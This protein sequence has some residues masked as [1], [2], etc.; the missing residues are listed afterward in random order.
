MAE[1]RRKDRRRG[2]SFRQHF[3]RFKVEGRLKQIGLPTAAVLLVAGLTFGRCDSSSITGPSA[4][5]EET[6]PTTSQTP[7]PTTSSASGGLDGA[8]RVVKKA[9]ARFPS[10]FLSMIHP[11]FKE[12]VFAKREGRV[13]VEY[14]DEEEEDENGKRWHKTKYRVHEYEDDE[15]EEGN[16]YRGRKQ[17]P[18]FAITWSGTFNTTVV[19]FFA[20]SSSNDRGF[21]L[22][23]T[24]P[25]TGQV[26][27][28]NLCDYEF[29]PTRYD[30]L[31]F[32]CL[33]PTTGRMSVCVTV[34]ATQ[35]TSVCPARTLTTAMPLE[36][37]L[38]AVRDA[39]N[40]LTLQ[41]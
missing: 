21:C 29:N 8:L 10:S 15:D 30:L 16:R 37:R 33:D 22:T 23:A 20:V 39:G 13:E 19:S 40:L 41:L 3:K 18:S 7:G 36:N 12:V 2:Y 17:S 14:E 34:A 35:L 5:S 4:V 6:A 32:E 11:C 28:G 24:N 9:V 25:L 1:E 38:F 31:F 26:E 27:K